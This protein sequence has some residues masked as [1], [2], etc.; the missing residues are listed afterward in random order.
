MK[1]FFLFPAF[2]FFQFTICYAQVNKS[3]RSDNKLRSRLDSAVNKAAIIY[4]QDSNAN[5]ISIGICWHGKKYSYNYGEV[6]KGTGILPTADNF[7]NLGSVAKTFVATMLAE[8]VVEK[9]ANL[10]DDIR[11]FLPGKYPNLEYHGHGIELVNLANHTSGLPAEFQNLSASARD[12][13]KRMSLPQ[14]VDFYSRYTAD[15]LLSDLHHVK[16]DTMPGAQFHYNSNAMM[17]LILLLERIYHQPYEQIVTDYLKK[18]LEMYDTR[19]VLSKEDMKRLAQGYDSKNQP[20][21]YANFKSYTGGPSMNSTVNDM[22]KYIQANLS[23]KDKA[24]WLTHQLTWG[25][26]DGSGLGLGWMMDTENGIR[27]IYHDGNTKIGFNTLCLFYPDKG[28]GY[29]IIVN[30]NI[31]QR[32]VGDI[33][34]NITQQLLK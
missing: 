28:L 11:K 3:V 33:E 21:Q 32:R 23:E 29:I 14:Q 20:Q 1:S 22:L 31:S 24:I 10:D 18:Q 12:S 16:L 17:L 27:Y 6:K 8:A 34:N 30:D 7:Y 9:K 13:I 25:K 15:S 4:M 5:G 19:T 26:K 2:A